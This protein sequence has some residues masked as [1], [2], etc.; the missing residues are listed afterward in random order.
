MEKFKDLYNQYFDQI[1]AWYEG[2]SNSI[3]TVSFF[4]SWS[5]VFCSLRS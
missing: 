1:I 2:L 3:S 4:C 5:S